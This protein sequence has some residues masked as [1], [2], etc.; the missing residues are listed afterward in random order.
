MDTKTLPKHTIIL[1][2]VNMPSEP[3]FSAQMFPLLGLLAKLIYQAKRK[4]SLITGQD[5]VF[6]QDSQDKP[7]RQ[8]SQ[9]YNVI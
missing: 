5:F 1:D 8:L 6:C 4:F 7:L 3:I 9:P 2:F